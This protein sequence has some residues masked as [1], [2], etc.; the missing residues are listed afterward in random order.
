MV[1]LGRYFRCA[2]TGVMPV[3]V[4]DTSYDNSHPWDSMFNGVPLSDVLHQSP[5]EVRLM[6]QVMVTMNPG[7]PE[8]F[9]RQTMMNPPVLDAGP[10]PPELTIGAVLSGDLQPGQLY[11]ASPSDFS[12]TLAG[13]EASS[14]PSLGG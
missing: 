6:R 4:A 3:Q 14:R 11:A 1:M 10:R 8:E 13:M 5:G 12:G 7:T 2:Y 9:I